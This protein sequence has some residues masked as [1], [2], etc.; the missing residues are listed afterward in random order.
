M[1]ANRTV[2]PRA[3]AKAALIQHVD[4]LIWLQREGLHRNARACARMLKARIRRIAGAKE[5]L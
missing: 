2:P 5:T 3:G 4:N 1:T